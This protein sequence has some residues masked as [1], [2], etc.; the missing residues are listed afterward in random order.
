MHE[1]LRALYLEDEPD[2]VELVVDLLEQ[3]SLKVTI[4]R[5]DNC[6]EFIA[7][8]EKSSFDI[9]F[10]DYQLPSCTGL[11]ALEAARR[12]APHT[13]FLLVSAVIGEETA[14]ESLK[15]GAT[16]YVLKSGLNRLAPA[17]QRAVREAKDLE[18]RKRAEAELIRR[19]KYFRALTENSL[20]ILSI[21]SRDGTFLYSSPSVN[22]VLGYR[23][24]ELA[25]KSVFELVHP[26]DLT[27]AKRV[28]EEIL[29]QPE[30]RITW[31][32]RHRRQP[33]SWC[34]L[35]V[36]G[37]NRL[38]DPEIA[39]VVLNLR[40]VTER[41]R[42]Q[43]EL[44]KTQV[45][46][47]NA[48]RVAET[49]EVAAGTVHNIGN[50]LNSLNVSV[51]LVLEQLKKSKAGN[52]GRIAGLLQEHAADIGEFVTHDPRGR[53]LPGYL[54]QLAERLAH[55]QS[56]LQQETEQIRKNLEY[57]KDTVTTQQNYAQV[58][59][60]AETVSVTDLVED[61]LRLNAGSLTRRDLK[62]VRDYPP[63]AP[64]VTVE[65]HKVLQVLINLIRNAEHACDEAGTGE[66]RL[67]LRVNNGDDRV[68]IVVT[69]NG[70]GIPAENLKQIFNHGFTT[71][72]NG[73]GFGLHSGA[74]TAKEMGGD[75]RAHSD[76]PGRGATFILELPCQTIVHEN[77]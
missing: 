23:P 75:L 26:D 38:D 57:M 17:V 36:V 18:L 54:N 22:H 49:A 77:A 24:E 59:G 20:D 50:V 30:Q 46:L 12:M 64:Q 63:Y 45:E 15:C 55:E 2:F 69:D 11:Q 1:P 33:G 29:K 73:H 66:K 61:A 34:H 43:A 31:E 27:G 65:K 19:E 47:A 4:T 67:L 39:G 48:S 5:V 35:E 14:I 51:S 41:K 8:L 74:K 62:I 70:V 9:I 56:A 42:A 72:K 6:P 3:E 32:F 68:R 76:G 58:S 40:D 71:K 10:A 28:F 52:L 53:Q 37:C 7:A 13:P 21:L 60:V 44:T 16:D 25:G